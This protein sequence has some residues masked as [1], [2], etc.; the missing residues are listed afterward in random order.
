MYATPPTTLTLQAAA[1]SRGQ[2][3]VVMR[4]MVHDAESRKYIAA[5]AANP[6]AASATET[7]PGIC[8]TTAMASASRAATR[9]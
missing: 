6:D 5:S 8:V 3:V 9:P 1:D 7:G 4:R 2:A